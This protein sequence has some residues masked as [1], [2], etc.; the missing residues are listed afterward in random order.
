MSSQ[1]VA[2]AGQKADE[3]KGLGEQHNLLIKEKA[4]LWPSLM[5][6]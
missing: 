5:S 3:L 1:N 6:M 2:T 4:V